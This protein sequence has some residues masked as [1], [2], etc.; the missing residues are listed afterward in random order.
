M[1]RV[2]IASK[3]VWMTE[4]GKHYPRQWS[5]GQGQRVGIARANVTDRSLQLAAEP[6]GAVDRKCGAV[7]I[8]RARDDATT[9][10]MVTH[11]PHAAE[12][13]KRTLHLEKGQ[14]MEGV[15]HA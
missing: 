6:S 9:L 12:R 14:L 3:V 13:A 11:A 10:A 1:E 15:V 8:A 4:R 2:S 5:G 7:T